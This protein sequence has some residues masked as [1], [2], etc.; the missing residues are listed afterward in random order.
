MRGGRC[1]V[2]IRPAVRGEAGLNDATPPRR[3][4]VLTLIALFKLAKSIACIV[5]AA[6]AFHLL[7][8]NVAA[9]VGRWLESL[10][11]ATRHGLVMRAIE[12]FV[13]LGPRQ[14]RVFGTAALAYAV[15]YAVQGIGL[16]FG[17]R[18][19]E[20]LIVVETGLLLP[21]EVWEL[22]HRFSV[23]KLG[24]LVTNIVI[25]AY[26]IHVLR[27]PRPQGASR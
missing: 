22:Q 27:K 13:D 17:R 24:V 16:W 9:H 1:I 5:L 18:W 26:L 6:M 14:F 19:A 21:I 20:Y 10:T 15:L 2:R 3:S 23:F 11:W 8:P 7:Q 4:R 25:V 12:W